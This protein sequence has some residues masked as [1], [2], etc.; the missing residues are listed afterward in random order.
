MDRRFL[1]T[2]CFFLAAASASTAESPPGTCQGTETFRYQVQVSLDG[3]TTWLSDSATMFMD[4]GATADVAVRTLLT[5]TSGQT[6][7]WS[8]SLK[9]DASWTQ[10]YGGSFSVNGVT[11]NGTGTATV[12]SGSPPDTNRTAIRTGY[13]GYTQGIVI[14]D[15]DT[16]ITLAPVTNF[17]TS[18]ACYRVTAPV[19]AGTYATTLQF[20]NDIGNPAVRSVIT[21]QGLS[22]VPCAKNFTLNIQ[23]GGSPQSYPTC[24]LPSG[25]FGGSAEEPD[26]PL[27]PGA[28]GTDFKRADASPDGNIDLSDP[29]YTLSYMFTSGPAPT[30]MDAAD[31]NDDEGIDISDPVYTLNF[32]FLAG[33][34]PPFPGPTLC[35]PDITDSDAATPLDCQSYT[36]CNQSDTD[37]DGLTDFAEPRTEINTDAGDPDMD[38]DGFTDGEEVLPAGVLG[39]DGTRFNIK[40]LGAIPKHKDIFIE[41]DWMEIV[42]DHSHQPNDNALI[43]V[44]NAF[45]DAP[46]PNP[47]GATGIT[48]HIDRGCVTDC[49]DPLNL[50]NV[51]NRL[52][53]REF[54]HQNADVSTQQGKDAFW[55][56][57]NTIK[58]GT[59]NGKPNFDPKRCNVFHY[60]VWAHSLTQL[61]VD[62]SG[63]AEGIP[64]DDFVISL[65][66]FPNQNGTEDQQAGTFMHEHGHTLGLRHGGDSDCNCKPN[67]YSVMSYNW[68]I[69]RPGNEANWRLNF[70]IGNYPALNES[71]LN[72][73]LGINGPVEDANRCVPVSG[74]GF[75]VSRLVNMRGRVD[76]NRS[77]ADPGCPTL[78][79]F[80]SC[81]DDFNDIVGDVNRSLFGCDGKSGCGPNGAEQ[82]SSSNRSPAHPSI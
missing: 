57:F 59:T 34:P 51:Q 46:V 27:P 79:D 7:A 48:L 35:G 82:I 25:P 73:P 50:G 77:C 58:D 56:E 15:D 10:Y 23:V 32:L 14:D 44:R 37:N 8:F 3:G 65:G 19:S 53:H 52:A 29:I 71:S 76:W 20:T 80:N 24:T 74:S 62:N 18:R 28:P 13:S 67:Y 2:A 38:G 55:S 81:I 12:Q 16:I 21:Q 31:S 68:Q 47:D 66:T 6:Q 49:D 61:Q 70:S 42:G 22:N 39:C 45:R 78:P 30:C 60:C 17:V 72:E 9:H 1:L 69:P 43:R 4:G 26:A 54:I 11:I 64:G 36:H 5:V 41:V 75:P 33:P 63:L 40:K